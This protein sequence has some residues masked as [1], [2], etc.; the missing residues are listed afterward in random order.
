MS[1]IKRL[2]MLMFALTAGCGGSIAEPEEL[3]SGSDGLAALATTETTL[4]FMVKNTAWGVSTLPRQWDWTPFVHGG[5]RHKKIIPGRDAFLVR[6]YSAS[7]VN[8]QLAA[9]RRNVNDHTRYSGDTAEDFRYF[10]I[11]SEAGALQRTPG[12]AAT[13]G[14]T[15]TECGADS[16]TCM[17]W[18]GG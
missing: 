13:G 9:V 15:A 11:T 12:D 16:S 5:K 2:A 1:T 3:G 8:T 4:I 10:V 14:G 17:A 7:S 18:R 6:A